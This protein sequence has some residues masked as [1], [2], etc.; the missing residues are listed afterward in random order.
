[1]KKWLRKIICILSVIVC[2]MVSN[3]TVYSA[4]EPDDTTIVT[5]TDEDLDYYYGEFS[6]RTLDKIS[7]TY[8]KHNFFSFDVSDSGRIALLFENAT[9][10]VFDD[11][12]N[13]KH[14]LK[15]NEDILNTRSRSAT[16]QWSGENLELTMGYDVSFL[17]TTSGEVLDIW[18]YETDIHTIPNPSSL[19]VEDCTYKMKSSNLFVHFTSNGSYDKLIRYDESSNERVIF[20]S[21]K[22]IPGTTILFVVILLS[23]AAALLFFLSTIK[24]ANNKKLSESG[25]VRK[26]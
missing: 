23:M 6:L 3:I 11:Y 26:H 20:E 16:I 14:I 18:Q 25:A 2:I 9:V 12:G 10:V 15:F 1:M 24:K 21:E 17:F 5:M 19:T 22:G 8:K 13:V 4:Y 7:E